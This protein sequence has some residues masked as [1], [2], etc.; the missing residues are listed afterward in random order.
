MKHGALW[1]ISVATTAEAADAVAEWLGKAFDQPASTDTSFVTGSTV[2]SVY[3][4]SPRSA[5]PTRRLALHDGL[6]RIKSFGLD[7]GTARISVRKIPRQDWAESWKRHF[8]PLVIGDALLIKPSWSKRRPQGGQVVVVID[9][10]L[11]FGTGQHPTTEFCL[12][13]LVTQ[14]DPASR[15][16]FLDIGT[17]SGI[18]AIAAAK[19]GYA[20][21]HAFDF[22]SQCV[23]VAR[24]NARSN[25][26]Q[27]QILITRADLTRL[28]RR[29]AWQFDVICAN[30]LANVLIAEGDR[31][32][33][34]LRPG[35]LLV[36]A[37]ILKSEFREVAAAYE[38]LGLELIASK[39]AKEW[40]SAT[41]AR[42]HGGVR[43]ER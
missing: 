29:A 40:R 35:G 34:R 24:A 31:I 5:F 4:E 2:V 9:P 15:Q 22:D 27:H 43:R 1:K 21:V 10:G 33:A 17:G 7:I 6:R 37:G 20:S 42:A 41:F 39:T 25:R 13:Q 12:R 14:R 38:N 26:V 16:S 19:L 18:L 28:P 11:S 32:L 30:L 8:K 3:C 36:V 23:R